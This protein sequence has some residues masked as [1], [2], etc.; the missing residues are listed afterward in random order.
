MQ[1]R[2][3]RPVGALRSKAKKRQGFGSRCYNEKMNDNHSEFL[4]YAEQI[5]AMVG[6]KAKLTKNKDEER[7]VFVSSNPKALD[8]TLTYHITGKLADVVSLDITGINTW[9]W[10]TEG[11]PADFHFEIAIAAL[12]GDVAN[13]ATR[14]MKHKELCFKVKDQWYCTR[15][16]NPNYGTLTTRR[17]IR[18]SSQ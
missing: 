1:L 3:S 2:K 7:W 11:M 5:K 9:F 16:G 4:K 14:I 6:V 18:E 17:K 12:K 15:T 10:N 8:V 13:N